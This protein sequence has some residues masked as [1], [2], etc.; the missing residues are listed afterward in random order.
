MKNE[1]S[2]VSEFWSKSEPVRDVGGF[3][4]SPLMR[5]YIIETAYGKDLVTEYRCNSYYAEDIFIS[6]YL[7]GKKIKS[8]PSLCCGFGSVE[9]RFVSQLSDVQQ[10]LGV[11]VAEGAL[12]IARK[13]AANEEMHCICCKCADLNN[14]PWERENYDLVRPIK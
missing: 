10:C 11:D 6:K 2:K 4:M 12:E 1:L 3:Y 5:P 7:R 9:R 14:Y 13:R 8:I